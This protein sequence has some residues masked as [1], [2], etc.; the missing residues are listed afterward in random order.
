MQCFPTV[1]EVLINYTIVKLIY[2][3]WKTPIGARCGIPFLRFATLCVMVVD[4]GGGDEIK[5]RPESS[6]F[7]HCECFDESS[8]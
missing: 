5:S 3:L 7:E 2:K 1:D 8:S 4:A 6:E